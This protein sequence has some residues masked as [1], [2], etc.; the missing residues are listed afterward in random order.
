M[1]A[2]PCCQLTRDKDTALPLPC[3]PPPP[4]SDPAPRC[5]LP[6]SQRV[7]RQEWPARQQWFRHPRARDRRWPHS[8]AGRQLSAGKRGARLDLPPSKG[9]FAGLA[10]YLVCA[11][12]AD[13][14]GGGGR[15]RGDSRGALTEGHCCSRFQHPSL[16]VHPPTRLPPPACRPS[17]LDC[18]TRMSPALKCLM[19]APTMARTWPEVVTCTSGNT[20]ATLAPAHPPTHLSTKHPPVHPG[21]RATSQASPIPTTA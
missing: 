11:P 4:S 6:P 14:S 19:M 9:S 21:T 10:A 17:C 8:G 2:S 15:V 12:T 5:L 3:S 13:V 16:A 18:M 1:H 20:C 7:C